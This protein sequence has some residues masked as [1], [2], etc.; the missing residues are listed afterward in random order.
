MLHDVH[1]SNII[2]NLAVDLHSMALWCSTHHLM[3]LHQY[4]FNIEVPS[5]VL[6]ICLA[7]PHLTDDSLPITY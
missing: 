5:N 3:I 4:I 1:N 2:T 6:G 7:I